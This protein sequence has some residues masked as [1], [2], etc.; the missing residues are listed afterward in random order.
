MNDTF[1]KRWHA[2]IIVGGFTVFDMLGERLLDKIGSSG[3]TMKG[4]R[5][6]SCH[7]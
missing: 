1:R 2:G 5:C 6:W 3:N 7:S 4:K